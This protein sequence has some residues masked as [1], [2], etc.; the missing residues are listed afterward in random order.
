MALE[1]L[2]FIS[3]ILLYPSHTTLPQIAQKIIS[4]QNGVYMTTSKACGVPKGGLGGSPLR[5][6]EVLTKLSR[7]PRSVENTYVTS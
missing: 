2:F 5:N 7:I 3:R 6:F 1:G 4:D